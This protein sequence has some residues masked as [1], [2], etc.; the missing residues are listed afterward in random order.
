ML[1]QNGLAGEHAPLELE[2]LELELEL[3]AEL[4][5]LEATLELLL[6]LLA[7]LPVIVTDA[8]YGVPSAATLALLSETVNDFVPLNEDALLIVMST[9]FAVASPA[10]QAKFPALEVKS[11]PSAAV[12]AKVLYATVAELE[13]PLVRVTVIVTLPALCATA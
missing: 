4:E 6:E 3:L 9:L 7:P 5:L 2:L 8:L 1:V 12:P 11:V 13:D 10:A